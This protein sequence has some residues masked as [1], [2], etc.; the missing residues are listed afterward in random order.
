[1]AFTKVYQLT[2]HGKLLTAAG[3]GCLPKADK[4]RVEALFPS[5]SLLGPH[6]I[7]MTTDVVNAS[8]SGQK[9]VALENSVSDKINI[10]R[11]RINP[12]ISIVEIASGC[13]SEC[14]FCQTR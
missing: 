8:I 2:E 1:M 10:P 6:S 3:S 13:L 4:E 14:A 5:A 7:D 9:I 11:I 12:T